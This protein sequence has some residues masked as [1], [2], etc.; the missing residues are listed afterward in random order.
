[1][2]KNVSKCINSFVNKHLSKT[3]L[4][5]FV[6]FDDNQIQIFKKIDLQ[7]LNTIECIISYF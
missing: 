7:I 1:M 4:L 2:M 5:R 6:N 3:S